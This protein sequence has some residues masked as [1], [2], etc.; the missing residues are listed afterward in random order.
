MVFVYAFFCCLH[1]TIFGRSFIEKRTQLLLLYGVIPRPNL[2]G[3]SCANQT[4][5]QSVD[6]QTQVPYLC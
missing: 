5:R 4:E 1:I 2:F 3:S 6:Q